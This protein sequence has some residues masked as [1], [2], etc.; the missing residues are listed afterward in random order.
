MSVLCFKCEM[1]GHYAHLCP[2]KGIKAAT[3]GMPN[4]TQDV[5]MN[6]SAGALKENKPDIDIEMMQPQS[7]VK[8]TKPMATPDLQQAAA[9]ANSQP[10]TQ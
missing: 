2:Q 10:V 8:A 4:G 6:P 1:Y 3:P 9:P 7:L 5:I